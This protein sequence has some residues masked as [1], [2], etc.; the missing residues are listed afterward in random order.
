[1]LEYLKLDD[2]NYLVTDVDGEVEIV[3]PK[4]KEER[5][6]LDKR[7]E[8]TDI[9]KDL[10]L[11]NK[12]IYNIASAIDYHNRKLKNSVLSSV[13]VFMMTSFLSS[14]LS[15]CDSSFPL[16]EAIIFNGTAVLSLEAFDVAKYVDY[17]VENNNKNNLSSLKESKEKIE[18][19]LYQIRN[20][21]ETI[22]CDSKN[23]TSK[24]KVEEFFY[25]DSDL[26]RIEANI[27]KS[28]KHPE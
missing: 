6:L 18:Q 3:N 15:F 14:F 8:Y 26:K 27:A 17:L 28:K 13:Y 1:M 16:K 22:I 7:A 21:L 2:N 20:E 12:L 9:R 23:N 4:N 19:R 10:S 25:T 5:K 24:R 11:C